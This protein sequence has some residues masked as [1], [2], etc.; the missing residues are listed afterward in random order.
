MDGKFDMYDEPIIKLAENI[1]TGDI[2]EIEYGDYGN[3]VKVIIDHIEKND[4]CFKTV[5]KY[6][7]NNQNFECYS[8]EET[9]SYKI[10]GKL[11]N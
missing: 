6:L 8:Y 11:L 4:D 7:D 3:F 5:G 10:I 9:Q 2:A 1:E